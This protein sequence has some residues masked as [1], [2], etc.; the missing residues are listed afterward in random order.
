MCAKKAI[1]LG[2][3]QEQSENT[4]E[5]NEKDQKSLV[6]VDKNVFLKPHHFIDI[7][8]SLLNPNDLGDNYMGN[9]SSNLTI[10]HNNVA[11][12]NLHFDEVIGLFDNCNR[13]PN[14]L[15]FTETK[16]ND[17]SYPPLKDYIFK[18]VNSPT[19]YG[20]VG[21]YISKH[22]NYKIRHDL[23]LQFKGCEDIWVSIDTSSSNDKRS[24]F[25]KNHLIL[26]VI[27]RHPVTSNYDDFCNKLCEKLHVINESK[28]NFVIVGDANVDILKY[29]IANNVTKYINT[30]N[31]YGAKPFINIPTRVT[32]RSATCLDH[33]YSN[34][35]NEKLDNFVISSDGSDHYTTLTRIEGISNTNLKDDIFV[36]KSNLTENEWK[37]FNNDLRLMLETKLPIKNNTMSANSFAEGITSVYQTISD[38]YM[39]LKKLSRKQKSFY[40][41]PWMTPALQ[42]SRKSKFEKLRRA[43][44]S[45]CPNLW[46]E[47]TYHRNLLTRLIQKS[48]D[49]YYR[50]K[51]ALYAQ[52]KSKLW[53]MVN[54]ICR[55]KRKKQ[56]TIK[57]M[58]DPAGNEQHKPF[59]I[60]N[61]L[62][63]HFTSIGSK[64]ASEIEKSARN[65]RDPLS[66]ITKYYENSLFIS[67]TNPDEVYRLVYKLDINKGSNGISNK[68]LKNTA[69]TSAPYLSVLF[70]KCISE[71]VFPNCFK[72]AKVT[73]LFKNGDRHDPSSY[74]PISLLPT[75]GKL[76][77][78]IIAV[79]MLKFLD[80]FDMLSE[81]Q[82]GFR[83][84][85]TTE[86]A[87]VDI[88]EKLLYNLDNRLTSCAIFLDLAK[89]FDS[90]SHS[91][92]LRK[93]EKY[94]IRGNAH[95]LL[96]SY[97]DKRSQFVKI[98]DSES[99]AKI[100]EF[101]VPQGSILGPLLFLIY[102]NDLP[103]ASNFFIKL[104][105]DDTFLCAQSDDITKFEHEINNE[106]EKVSAWLISN[107]LTL[108]IKKSKFM[109]ISN[110]RNIP[111]DFKLKIDN[112]NLGRCTSY[113][114]LG[115]YFDE[116]L[117]WKTHIEHVSSKIS[118][119]CGCLTKLRNCVS[120]NVLRD[121]YHALINSYLQYLIM[122]LTGAQ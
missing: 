88:F 16:L 32:D 90:V 56:N 50:D 120:T 84:K 14:I 112:R 114:Y 39:P 11:S 6:K 24:I 93:L 66:Y 92:L 89:A 33:V 18:G 52:D 74:R 20:G 85:F 119:A 35:E 64:M 102:I 118:K 46:Q 27:Y 36:R 95:D 31:S 79:R 48:H 106:L 107:K 99:V 55:R 122:R 81:H 1:L 13:L 40:L 51:C 28:S 61:S 44:K 21:V 2:E 43:V 42:T 53:K 37:N 80:K 98:G 78:K 54:E 26:G 47:Y 86:Y 76:L 70:N 23:S 60:A 57:S 63:D 69:I 19:D 25:S 68:T 3:S 96:S 71:G 110:K 7:K 105:A 91:I 41:K 29:N 22:I 59:D 58:V 121:V 73:P 8:C 38:I 67:G 100:V 87:I 30:L 17:D 75:I 94:G 49:N 12:L 83:P 4:E 9:A 103:Q 117:D 111:T 108:N 104:Y 65:I 10:L 5:K 45:N 113:K 15:A 72:I 62:N 34:F 77:E 109:L 97:L 116:N 82:L 101:G 115:V